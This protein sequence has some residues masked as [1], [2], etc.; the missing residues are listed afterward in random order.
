MF[1]L[2][3]P[4]LRWP[5]HT[6]VNAKA[7]RSANGGWV[8]FVCTS[9]TAPDVLRF[10][11]SGEANSMAEFLSTQINGMRRLRGIK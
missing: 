7:S 2:E 5:L 11:K 6:Y 10:D 4:L 3:I 8:V 9:T 1:D